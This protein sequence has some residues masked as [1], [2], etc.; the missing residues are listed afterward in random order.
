LH[1]YS[2]DKGEFTLY[3]DDG[4]TEEY[5]NGRY[6]ETKIILEDGKEPCV[7]ICETTGSFLR[8]EEYDF[9]VIMHQ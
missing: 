1:V 2:G 7:K 4:H 6:C 9:K 5:L 8:S 3:N